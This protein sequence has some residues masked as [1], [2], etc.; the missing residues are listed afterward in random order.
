MM[1]YVFKDYLASNRVDWLLI[2]GRWVQR[3]LPGL[4]EVLKWARSRASPSR[5]LAQ[6]SSTTKPCLGS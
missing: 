1:D 5:Y 2:G 6:W 4:E 3:D